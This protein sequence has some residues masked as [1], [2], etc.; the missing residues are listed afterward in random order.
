M[1]HER[2]ILCLSYENFT[3]LNS[4][5]PKGQCAVEDEVSYD[6]VKGTLLCRVPAELP[7]CVESNGGDDDG[8]VAKCKSDV[9]QCVGLLEFEGGKVVWEGVVGGILEICMQL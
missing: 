6:S 4:P 5:Y 2:S 7:I 9:S 3:L 1:T 8:C